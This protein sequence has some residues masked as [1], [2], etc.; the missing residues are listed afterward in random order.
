[1]QT[2][3]KHTNN[4]N[5]ENC[6]IS[7]LAHSHNFKHSNAQG[8]NNPICTFINKNSHILIDFQQSLNIRSC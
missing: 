7:H 2:R 8:F 4:Q 1:M 5:H 3:I 6:N